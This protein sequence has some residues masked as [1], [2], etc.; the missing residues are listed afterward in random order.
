MKYSW[1]VNPLKLER[2]IKNAGKDATEEEVKALYISYGGK[3]IE[4]YDTT[5]DGESDTPVSEGKPT[6]RGSKRTIVS[7]SK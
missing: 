6:A 3:V 4:T 7:H 2:A 5:N 1:S